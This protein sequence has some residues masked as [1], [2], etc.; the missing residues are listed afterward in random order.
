MLK[1]HEPDHEQQVK[2]SQKLCMNKG[3]ITEIKLS[4]IWHIAFLIY[5]SSKI[6]QDSCWIY[7]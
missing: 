3:C 7:Q 5:L 2:L 1:G 6:C 4:Q